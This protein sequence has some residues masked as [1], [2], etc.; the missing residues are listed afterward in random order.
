M[1]SV[2]DEVVAQAT[3]RSGKLYIQDRREFD[4]RLARLNERWQ[5]EVTVRRLVATRSPQ[6]NKYYWGVVVHLLSEHTGHSPEEIH[7][8]L[9]AKFIPK[10]C[11]VQDGN[12]EIVGEF[13]LG[14]ST[15]QMN[16]AAFQDYI[17]TIRRWS[18]E[19]LDVYIPD[20]NEGAL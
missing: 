19:V 12:G 3:V 5:L 7:D 17:E 4:Q 11:A 20:P 10:T 2:L 18:A 9:K 15:R 13:V 16:T 6:A 14:G 8:I 1:A